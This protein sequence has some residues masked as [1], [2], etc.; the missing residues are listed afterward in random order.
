MRNNNK[1]RRRSM[2]ATPTR[3][4]NNNQWQGAQEDPKQNQDRVQGRARTGLLLKWYIRN[5]GRGRNKE[6][7]ED[8]YRRREKK[9]GEQTNVSSK[10][11]EIITHLSEEHR[12]AMPWNGQQHKYY[13]GV[14][15]G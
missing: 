3:P 12:G 1:E 2:N 5:S 6:I 7:K 4:S 10:Q 8:T 13:W 15:T 14:Q 11:Y 9:Q